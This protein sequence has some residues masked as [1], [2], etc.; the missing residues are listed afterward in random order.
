MKEIQWLRNIGMAEGFSFIIL[1]F[2][3]MP[4]KYM[5]NMPLAVKYVGWTHGVL[6]VGYLG[7]AY[8]VKL[9]RQQPFIRLIYAFVAALV[10]FGTFVYDRELKKDLT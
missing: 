7:M 9:V 4:L 3:A 1:L 6:F 10:P 2:I 8:Y 5:Y